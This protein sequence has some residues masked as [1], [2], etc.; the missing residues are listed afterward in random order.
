MKQIFPILAALLLSAGGALAASPPAEGVKTPADARELVPP[1]VQAKNAGTAIPKPVIKVE[2][3]EDTGMAPTEARE[4]K[5]YAFQPQEAMDWKASAF[6]PLVARTWSDKG[7]DAEEARAWLDSTRQNRTLM[8]E[9]DQTDPSAWKREGFTPADRL[10]WWEAGF[11]FE[12]AVLLA[13]SG[14]TPADAAWHGHDK[15]K[16]LKEQPGT[17]VETKTETTSTSIKL[18]DMERL[19][20]LGRPYLKTAAAIVLGFF[21]LIADFLYIRNRRIKR[22]LLAADANGPDTEAPELAPRAASPDKQTTF[23]SRRPARR[24]AFTKGGANHCIHCKSLDVRPSRMNPHRFAGIN[25]TEYFRCRHCGRHFAVVTYTP[26]VLA[27]GGVVLVLT[28]ISSSFIY[29][30][31][32]AP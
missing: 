6:T 9:L 23:K 4:W 2:R 28:L 11:A 8:A 13:R 1:S 7:F 31:S 18:P 32:L 21:A 22:T 3:W 19:I 16:E 30:L 29:L 14:M 15:L 27:A 5:A 25:F 26:I 12:D 17:P 20:E 24:M 10:A